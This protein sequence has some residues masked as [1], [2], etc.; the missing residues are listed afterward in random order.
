MR[1][2]SLAYTYFES[3]IGALLLA[4][5]TDALQVLGFPSGSR[6][7]EPA[8]TWIRDDRVFRDVRDQLAAYFTGELRAFDIAIDPRGTPFQQHVWHL[9]ATIPYGETRSYG[10]LALTLGASGASRAVGA[11]NG[12]NPL[13]I[14]LPCHRV[15]GSTGKL[16]GFGGG[17]ATK[18]Y[19]LDLEARVAGHTTLTLL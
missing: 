8:P 13:P 15:I 19:L 10:D 6:A 11:A 18:R 14:I 12:A 5:E 3:P 2:A 4:G 7:M 9:L 16:T 1:G 17:I